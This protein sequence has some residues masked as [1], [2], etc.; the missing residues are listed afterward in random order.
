MWNFTV[1]CPESKINK[2][3]PPFYFVSIGKN[4]TET[5]SRQSQYMGDIYGYKAN[6]L[7]SKNKIHIFLLAVFLLYIIWIPISASKLLYLSRIILT[8][9][10]ENIKN[11]DIDIYTE[12][13]WIFSLT[14]AQNEYAERTGEVWFIEKTFIC[15][16]NMINKSGRPSNS[17]ME[18]KKSKDEW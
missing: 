12:I 10:T 4:G 14:I 13:A 15:S 17:L 8:Q 11:V 5:F 1:I 18:N 7:N 2:R 3:V 6:H 16:E 9:I